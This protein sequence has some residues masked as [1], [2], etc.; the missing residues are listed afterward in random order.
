[1]KQEVLKKEPGGTIIYEN[2]RAEMRE[3]QGVILMR[4]TSKMWLKELESKS[5]KI[6]QKGARDGKHY[7]FLSQELSITAN[8]NEG[9]EKEEKIF[10]AIM[11]I[12][13][14]LEILTMSSVIKDRG[15]RLS[16]LL[17]VGCK[18]YDRFSIKHAEV[19]LNMHVIDILVILP[20][21]IYLREILKHMYQE[22]CKRMLMAA[23]PFIG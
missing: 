1:M 5:E 16:H 12:W 15:K 21:G 8:R 9:T 23:L 2:T 19:K 4:D 14:K 17:S 11:R 13:T 10:E 22:I 3:T 18:Q 6:F 7:F 20:L